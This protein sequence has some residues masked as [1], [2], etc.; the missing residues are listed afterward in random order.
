MKKFDYQ[1]VTSENKWE[2]GGVQETQEE[3]D[4]AVSEV[5]LRLNEEGRDEKI[6]VFKAEKM[7]QYTVKL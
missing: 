6:I 1:I 3:I 5:K 4:E 2:G 7:E